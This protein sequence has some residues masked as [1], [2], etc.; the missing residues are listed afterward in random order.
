MSRY[1]GLVRR[2]RLLCL[3]LLCLLPGTLPA[4]EEEP[5]LR[6]LTQALEQNPE[7]VAAQANLVAAQER[8]PQSRA[9]LLPN[10]ALQISPTHSHSRWHNGTLTEHSLVAGVHLSQ[11]LYNRAALIAFAQSE[12]YIGA[13][14]DDWDGAVQGIFFKVAKT[15]VDLLQAREIARLAANNRQVMHQH[16]LATQSRHHVGEI[17]RTSVSQAEARLAAAQAEQFRADNA[18]AVAQANF[19]EVV[20]AEAPDGL[21]LPTF[22]HPPDGESPLEH[23]VRHLEQ[24]PDMRASSKRLAVAEA[25]IAQ[26][27]AGHWPTVALTSSANHTW[28]RGV[29]EEV[30]KYSVGMKVELPLFAGGMTLS[31]SAEAQAR[32][33]AQWAQR[34]RLRRQAYREIEK[35]RLDLRSSQALADSFNSMVT[36]AQMAR[37]GVERE[38]RVGSRTA[39]DLLDAEHELFANQTELAKN[40]YGLALARFQ[41]LWSAGR[42]TLEELVF[43]QGST[44]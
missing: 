43:R 25:A 31:K 18:V 21:V 23:W 10:V 9:A 42:L 19:Y 40:R 17:T 26:E 6:A 30:D 22:R 41:M 16:L 24:R 27:Q 2:C 33:D 5:F 3:A 28:Q 20:G 14:A 13:F 29:T 12:P 15:T 11:V 4:N 34:D 32:R 36:A 35:A 7:I 8:L 1:T 44:P 39:L 37:D 38:F